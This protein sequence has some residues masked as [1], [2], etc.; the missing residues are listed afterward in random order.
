MPNKTIYHFMKSL[1]TRM[2]ANYKR[3]FGPTRI[4]LLMTTIGRKSGL[5]RVT[6]LQFEEGDG[7]YYIASVRGRRQIGSKHPGQPECP[8]ANPG[9]GV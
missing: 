8:C 3:G 6:P 1:D 7:D 4:V 5:A 2:A 9:A